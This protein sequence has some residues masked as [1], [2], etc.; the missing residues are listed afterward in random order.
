MTRSTGQSAEPLPPAARMARI[1]SSRD[2]FPS[3]RRRISM[4]AVSQN[5][6]P[7]H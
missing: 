6:Q 3:V 1:A 2:F 5:R 4:S 7:P